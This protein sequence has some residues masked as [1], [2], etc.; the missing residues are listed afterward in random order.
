MYR[1]TRLGLVAAVV[2]VAGCYAEGGYTT[3]SVGY[4][5]DL[6]YVAPGVQ[7]IADYDEP[8]FYS[9]NFYWR[10]DGGTWYRSPHYNG[11]WVH[12]NPPPALLRID[13]PRRYVHYRP[14]GWVAKRGPDRRQPM[15]RDHRDSPPRYEQRRN[16]PPVVLPPRDRDRDDRHQKDKHDRDRDRDHR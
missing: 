16:P 2:L 1:L 7:V 12:Q 11:G 10:F 9:D 3:P 13:E 4:S 15:V 6:V 8:I 5:A 14:Q